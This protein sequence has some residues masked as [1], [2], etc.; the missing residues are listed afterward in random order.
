MAFDNNWKVCMMTVVFMRNCTVFSNQ[1]IKP[2][3][4]ATRQDLT[5]FSVDEGGWV[6]SR[7]GCLGSGGFEDGIPGSRVPD[8]VPRCGTI[9]SVVNNVG[10]QIFSLFKLQ[11][12]FV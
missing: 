5:R 1:G 2:S 7:R 9:F 12:I 4:K 6:E 10:Q 8:T 3:Q 11:Q